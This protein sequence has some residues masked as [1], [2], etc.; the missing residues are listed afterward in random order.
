MP[1]DYTN[2][3]LKKGKK[4]AARQADPTAQSAVFG[5]E[6]SKPVIGAA[7]LGKEGVGYEEYANILGAR[8]PGTDKDIRGRQVDEAIFGGTIESSR[9]ADE[10]EARWAEGK[11]F[12]MGE[13]ERAHSDPSLTDEHMRRMM[14]LGYD[15]AAGAYRSNMASIRDAL[16]FTGGGMAAGFARDAEMQRLGQMDAVRT[17]AVLEKAKSDALDRERRWQASSPVYSALTKEADATRQNWL[18]TVLGIRLGQQYGEQQMELGR[19][20]STAAKQGAM[21]GAGGNLIGGA[22]GLAG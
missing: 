6:V 19:E 16:G 20:A 17:N 21:I 22:L 10:N 15:E 18:Q 9:I 1:Y 3:R 5:Q 7:L 14:G 4:K 13:F 12:L 8:G 11:G 2:E